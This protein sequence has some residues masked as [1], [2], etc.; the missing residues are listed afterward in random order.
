MTFTKTFAELTAAL[1]RENCSLGELALREQESESD[2]PRAEIAAEFVRRIG[3]MR[4][5]VR[6]GTAQATPTLS[7][8][9][10]MTARQVMNGPA[11]FG[12]LVRRACAYALATN[13]ESARME[14]IVACPT[15]GASGTVPGCLLA[16]ADEY[17][18][19]NEQLVAPMAA[20]GKIGALIG[21][22]ATLS[23]ARGGC[24][25]EVGVASA[26]GAAAL[27]EL[28]GGAHPGSGPMAIHAAALALKNSLGLVCDPIAGLVEVPCVK[29]NAIYALHAI[30]AAQLALSGVTSVVP[31]DEIVA[32]MVSIGDL[33]HPALKE[34]AEGGLA[35]T[36]TGIQITKKL[37]TITWESLGK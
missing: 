5:A 20:A 6:Q 4:A 1:N 36:I 12:D 21:A 34:S 27:A 13:E 31:M 15:A 17:K 32:A 7:G 11:P 23:G 16:Y 25:A 22:R 3:L 28:I 37:Q 24:Q 9:V 10:G 29:R 8:M 2:R 18:V 14:R 26:M 35:T 30:A 19:A 33:M